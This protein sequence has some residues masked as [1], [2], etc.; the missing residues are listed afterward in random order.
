MKRL[1]VEKKVSYKEKVLILAIFPLLL[2]FTLL[3]WGRSNLFEGFFKILIHPGILVT[4][5]IE[6]GGYYQSL[7]NVLLVSAFNLLIIYILK[8]PING[9][10][11]A[12]Y[13]VALGFSFFGKSII[14]ILPIYLGGF[15]YSRHE[16]VKFRS[17]FAVMMFA[18]GLAPVVSFLLFNKSLNLY[19]SIPSGIIM[20]V[21]IGFVI[22]PLSSHMLKFHDGYN[23]YNIG[24]TIGV[25]GTV[26][27]SVLKSF[28]L[29]IDKFYILSDQY[30]FKLKILLSITFVIFILIGYVINRYSFSG[31]DQLMASSGRV[32]S[33]YILTEGYGLALINAGVLGLLS[34]SFVNILGAPLNGP[35]VAGIFTVF[36]FGAFG[37]HPVNTIPIVLGVFL[38]SLAKVG[39]YNVFSVAL[40]GLFGTTL[41]PISGVHGPFL[42]IIA[43]AL[44][45]FL[46]SN[47]GVVHGGMNLYNNGFS[48]GLVA[49]VLVPIIHKFDLGEKFNERIY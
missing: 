4:D 42:G 17:I 20:G 49:G 45:F 47:V 21:I 15:L 16:K 23:L 31:Y 26:I 30:D 28:G 22:T 44:H 24:F 37:K 39:D 40:T 10:I 19:V 34:V 13:F 5:Y 48:G 9:L 14:N 7:F 8:I 6:V 2:F 3:F 33:D 29:T 32:I 11:F 25:L 1:K 27:A 46:V 36:G 41:A 35:L 38:A 43:G 18:T 12:G